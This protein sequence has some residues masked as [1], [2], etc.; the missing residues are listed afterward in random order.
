MRAWN[1]RNH[2]PYASRSSCNVGAA[3]F[4][5]GVLRLA[6]GAVLR[7]RWGHS[8]RRNQGWF[9]WLMTSV[10]MEG[11][12]PSVIKKKS[13]L[14]IYRHHHRPHHQLKSMTD[15]LLILAYSKSTC[16]YA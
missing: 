1:E 11:A 5:T 9:S 15:V 13:T 16:Q 8:S 12:T 4:P 3:V 10:M 7:P 6:V 2:D 14:Q